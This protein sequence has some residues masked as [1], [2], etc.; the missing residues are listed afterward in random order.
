MWGTRER[1]AARKTARRGE[2]EVATRRGARNGP[3]ARR[4]PSRAVCSV[5]ASACAVQLSLLPAV[6]SAVRS[7][8]KGV[9]G[10]GHSRV[11]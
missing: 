10:L 11:L 8:N 4:Q 6:P 3:R 5:P 2:G 1:V 9:P 7:G